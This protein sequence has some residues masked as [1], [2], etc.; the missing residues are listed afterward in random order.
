MRKGPG[1]TGTSDN[2]H[3]NTAFALGVGATLAGLVYPQFGSFLF[4]IPLGLAA[5][6]FGVLGFRGTQE[7]RARRFAVVGALLGLIGP[8]ATVF[9]WIL[10]IEIFDLPWC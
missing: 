3:A 2:S 1:G 8:T 6:V 5:V 9:V 4:G 10:V 7:S